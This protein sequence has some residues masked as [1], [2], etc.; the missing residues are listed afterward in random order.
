MR[1][2]AERGTTMNKSII[3]KNTIDIIIRNMPES[4][5]KLYESGEAIRLNIIRQK[6]LHGYGRTLYVRIWKDVMIESDMT[7]FYPAD[8]IARDVIGYFVYGK[9]APVR[10]GYD[11]TDSVWNGDFGIRFSL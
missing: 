5:R 2:N 9:K 10:I 4:F 8:R 6:N 1:K 11:G 7:E 3:D